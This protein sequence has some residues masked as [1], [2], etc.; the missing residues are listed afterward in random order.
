[1]I[2]DCYIKILPRASSMGFLFAHYSEERFTPI[3]KSL[4]G[5]DMLGNL[6]VGCKV[7]AKSV[8]EFYYI[9]KRKIT[10]LDSRHIVST[11]SS[12]GKFFQLVKH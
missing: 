2:D 11:N 3:Y 1:M 7:T 6:H 12:S 9:L 5:D 10:D 8:V 4:Y